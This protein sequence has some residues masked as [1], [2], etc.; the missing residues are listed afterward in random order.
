MNE[1]P[2]ERKAMRYECRATRGY[3]LEVVYMRALNMQILCKL[4]WSSKFIAHAI[5]GYLT[6]AHI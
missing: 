6:Q 5:G 2:K 3:G 1:H 4:D